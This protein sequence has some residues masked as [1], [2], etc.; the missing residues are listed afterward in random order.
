MET[1]EL[2]K[3]VVDTY[4][5]LAI[6]YGEVG[7]NARK[8]LEDIRRGRVKGLIPFTVVYEY[9]VH[10][11]RGKIP[12][13]KSID[14]VV[15]YLKSYFKVETLEFNDYVEA[16][17]IKVSGD[18]VL[19]EAEDEALKVRRLSIVDST[20]IALARREKAPHSIGRQRSSICC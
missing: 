1:E 6:V 11:L 10:W 18:K 13:L 17:R 12:G 16:A 19:R 7:E 20:V 5:L 9:V 4:A 3:V 2:K 15:T 14:E 8:I